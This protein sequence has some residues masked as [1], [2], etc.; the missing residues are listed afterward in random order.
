[1]LDKSDLDQMIDHEK[2]RTALEYQH[3]AW[4][5]GLSDG[6]E[7]EIMAEAAFATAV[8]ELVDE[9]GESAT[10]AYLDELRAKIIAGEFSEHTLQ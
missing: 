3:E 9:A 8:T 2:R 5:G 7:M 6:I 1:M 4:A 10:L